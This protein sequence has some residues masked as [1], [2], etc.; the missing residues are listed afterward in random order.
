MFRVG[1]DTNEAKLFPVLR[2][3]EHPRYSSVTD[4][5]DIGL[6]QTILPMIWSRGVGPIC[7]PFYYPDVDFSGVDVI[8]SGWGTT[9]FGGRKSDYL[10]KVDLTVLRNSDEKCVLSYPQI[11][12]SQMCTYKEGKDTCQVSSYKLST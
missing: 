3:I 6:V 8:A 10:Q 9:E 12:D 4:V 1:T 11:Q 5:N 7:L 2:F